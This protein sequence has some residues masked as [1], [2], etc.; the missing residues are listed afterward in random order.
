MTGTEF[1]ALAL[2]MRLHKSSA[3]RNALCMVLVDGASISEAAAANLIQDSHVKTVLESAC[4]TVARAQVLHRVVMP[5]I[6]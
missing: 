2:L 4:T 5:D 3:S 6:T 1:E